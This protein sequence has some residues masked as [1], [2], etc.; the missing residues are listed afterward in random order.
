MSRPS[1]HSWAESAPEWPPKNSPGGFGVNLK[2][3]GGFY[4]HHNSSALEDESA[5]TPDFEKDDP[6]LAAPQPERK[7]FAKIEQRT[8][9][10]RNLSDRASHK[11]IVDFVRGGLVLDI[12]LRSHE[13]ERSASISFVEGSAAQEFMNYV[14]R[15]DIY[16]H[17]KRVFPPLTFQKQGNLLTDRFQ[18]AFSWSERQFS[19]PGHVAN[20]IGIGAWIRILC[21]ALSTKDELLEVSTGYYVLQFV[22]GML[23]SEFDSGATRNLIIRNIHPSITEERIRDHL[24]HIHNIV[25]I[26]VS[27]E[28][29]DAYISLSSIN[30]SL[31][32]RTCMMSRL[33]YKG[34]K[35][36]WYP[37]ECS[38]PLPKIQYAPKK[39][40]LAPQQP[41]KFAS[42]VNRFQMLNM[43]NDGTE[44]GSDETDEEPTLLSDLSSMNISSSRSPWNPRTIAA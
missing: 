2:G 16:V 5:F 36:E 21:F 43:D 14:K 30:N 28:N 1:G 37:D 20:K 44:D 42:A 33:T 24:D 32:A 35:I 18:L 40:N 6:Y 3:K 27:F 25:I 41:K 23:T 7:R 17:G 15:N 34:M 31:F 12:Y 19:L 4:N 13:R 8:I 9:F 11:D 29:G 22:S 38:Q 26:S 39:E 10:A